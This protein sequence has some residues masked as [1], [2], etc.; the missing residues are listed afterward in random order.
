[1]SSTATATLR[2]VNGNLSARLARLSPELNPSALLHPEDFSSLLTALLQARDCLRGIAP[3]SAPDAELEKVIFEYRNTVEQLAQ[4]LPR[5]HG[6]LL[7]EK[8]RLE[9]AR[10][11]VIA[12]AAWA[13][14]SQNTL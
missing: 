7:T 5:I 2:I 13:Q 3:G 11:H 8:A 12:T 1:M 14:T 10:A 4:I 6:K 9:I